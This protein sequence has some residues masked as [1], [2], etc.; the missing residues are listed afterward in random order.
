VLALENTKVPSLYVTH[1]MNKRKKGCHVELHGGAP[2]LAGHSLAP[3][4]RGFLGPKALLE[5]FWKY[6][7]RWFSKNIHKVI[8]TNHGTNFPRPLNPKI[9]L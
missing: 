2:P 9:F 7:K 8:F 5:A 3:P 1:K 6:P 4:M